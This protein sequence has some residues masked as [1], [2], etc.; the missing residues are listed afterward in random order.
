MF[1]C[2]R[3]AGTA[4]SQEGDAI[5]PLATGGD[6]RAPDLIQPCNDSLLARMNNLDLAERAAVLSCTEK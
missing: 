5:L 4:F 1:G 2:C 3:F 6:A